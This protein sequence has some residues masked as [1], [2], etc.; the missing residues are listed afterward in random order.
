MQIL[1]AV[2][3]HVQR[4]H[5]IAQLLQLQPFFTRLFIAGEKVQ[6]NGIGRFELPSPPSIPW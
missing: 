3:G 6:D 2:G 5:L 4:E 1:G